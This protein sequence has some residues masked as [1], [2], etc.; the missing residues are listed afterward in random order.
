MKVA[1]IGCGNISKKHLEA[2]APL[3]GVTLCAAADIRPER[4]A[5][6][7]AQY[8]GRAYGDYKE[9]LQK[10]RP[11]AVHVC[12]PHDL[13]VP[14]ALDA[15]QAGCHVFCEKPA[16]ISLDGLRALQN[17][18]K[19]SGRQVG[20][21]FQNR[22]NAGAVKARELLQAETYGRLLAIRAAVDWCRG[23]DYYADDWHGRKAREGGGV[24]INQAIHTLDLVQYFAG[25]PARCVQAHTANDH[26][27][28]VIDVEDTAQLTCRFQNG[29]LARLNATT[30]FAVNA[31]VVIDLFTERALL[32]LEGATLSRVEADGS[33][34]VL[35]QPDVHAKG[36]KAYW[37]TG[38]RTMIAAFYRCAETGEPF[39]VDAFEGGKAVELFLAAY[40]SAEENGREIVL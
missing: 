20:V 1:L 40:R 8:G 11:D 33:A 28:G 29:V 23:A 5:A 27:Q 21:C 19:E 31:P 6:V 10:E 32:R 15:L 4:A 37:G 36:G 35:A 7:C 26:L 12:T 34:E 25:S 13:H 9:M 30:A 17:A 38:H 3:D 2:L 22:C 16:A 39:P 18:Q 24:L 14:M